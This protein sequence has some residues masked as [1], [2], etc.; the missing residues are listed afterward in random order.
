MAHLSLNQE[1]K[2]KNDITYRYVFNAHLLV[3]KYKVRCV[4]DADIMTKLT[5]TRLILNQHQS[6]FVKKAEN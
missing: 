4:R 5:V 2:Y 1:Q 3:G 6:W